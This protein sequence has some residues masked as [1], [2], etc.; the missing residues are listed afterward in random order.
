MFQ[1]QVQ[2]SCIF[3]RP[4][5]DLNLIFSDHILAFL[6]DNR[7]PSNNNN[8]IIIVLLL[9]VVVVAVVVVVVAVVIIDTAVIDVVNVGC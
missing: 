4:T 9:V 8:Y 7:E 3:V 5:E 1:F 2:A 6:G